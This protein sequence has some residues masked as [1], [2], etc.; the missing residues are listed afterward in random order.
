MEQVPSTAVV[1][2]VDKLL[3]DENICWR[4]IVFEGSVLG[5]C[6]TNFSPVW[7]VTARSGILADAQEITNFRRGE[8]GGW[9]C[10]IL[11]NPF[12]ASVATG[13]VVCKPCSC[14]LGK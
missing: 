13:N 3:K 1:K 9:C 6:A 10:H 7:S 12:R 5:D 14:F 4:G 11:E 8:S 2:A